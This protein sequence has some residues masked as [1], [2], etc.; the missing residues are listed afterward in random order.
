MSF[1]SKPISA[2]SPKTYP[3]PCALF[4]ERS[5]PERGALTL[6]T[7]MTP[8]SFSKISSFH[9]RSAR[10]FFRIAC[11]CSLKMQPPFG[12]YIPRARPGMIEN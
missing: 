10:P 1:V 8:R 6:L 12:Y 5:L 9:E 7:A 3:A 11:S 2:H 4:S